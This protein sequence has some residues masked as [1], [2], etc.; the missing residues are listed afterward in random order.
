MPNSVFLHI[1][2]TGGSFV[3]RALL[4]HVEGSREF[5]LD[6]NWHIDLKD[7]PDRE[8]FI[9]AFVRHPL[10]WWKSYWRFKMGVDWSLNNP[11]LDPFVKS[12]NFEEFMENVLKYKPGF[13]TSVFERRIGDKANEIDFIGKY[14]NIVEDLIKALKN[15]G[16]VFDENGIRDMEKINESDKNKF[17]TDLNV[18]LEKR[19]IMS[20]FSAIERFGY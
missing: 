9:F 10:E 12:D 1:P 14:E 18:D 17:N 11:N 16:E 19:I 2:K 5:Y 6:G 13:C 8:K 4:L 20:E 15:A 7:C 3:A